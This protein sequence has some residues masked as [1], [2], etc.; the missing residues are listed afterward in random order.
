MENYP[1][2]DQGITGLEFAHRLT[3]QAKRFGVE[4]LQTTGVKNIQRDGR[5]LCVQTTN[6]QEYSA[7][8]V[9]VATGAHY[10]LLGVPGE[11]QLI[12]SA[13]HFCSVC[14]GPFYKD[15]DI[16]VVGGGNSGFQEALF[17]KQFARHI[18]IV[19][20]MP[21]VRAGKFLQEAVAQRSDMTLVTN[22]AI[23]AFRGSRG[24]LTGVEVMDRASGEVKT[25][26]PDGVFVF[27]GQEPNTDWLPPEIKRDRLGFIVTDNRLETSLPGTFAAGDV[28]GGQHQ[29]SC[30]SRRR[31]RHGRVDD[32]GLLEAAP[33]EGLGIGGRALVISC[34]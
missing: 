19:E 12:G 9:L 21:E 33:I 6:D 4:I 31:R 23:Q 13:I 27:I 34:Q 24:K 25:W 17:L 15:K 5:Y 11:Y 26:Q 29:A 20:F 1:G 16:L 7:S 10:R 3:N 30:C 2:F 18:T 8:A 32:T 28:R 22:H 14:D